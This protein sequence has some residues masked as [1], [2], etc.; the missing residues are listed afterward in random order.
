ML[1]LSGGELERTMSDDTKQVKDADEMA[2]ALDSIRCS[3]SVDFHSPL[4][5]GQ[6]CRD[7]AIEALSNAHIRS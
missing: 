3:S 7:V 6:W 4:E 1:V 5:W 2:K